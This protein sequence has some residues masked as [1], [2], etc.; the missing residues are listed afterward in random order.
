MIHKSTVLIESLHKVNWASYSFHGISCF[1]VLLCSVS[2]ILCG[3][4]Y[5]LCGTHY[6]LCGSPYILFILPSILCCAPLHLLQCSALPSSPAWPP[7]I[8][9]GK[10]GCGESIQRPH[11]AAP[12][13]VVMQRLGRAGRDTRCTRQESGNKSRKQKYGLILTLFFNIFIM[14]QSTCCFLS[15]PFQLNFFVIEM[16]SCSPEKMQI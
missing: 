1:M 16:W 4:H 6:I 8:W 13:M 15:K 12:W 11:V 7:C 3:T 10:C 9:S 14:I 5:I 2:S